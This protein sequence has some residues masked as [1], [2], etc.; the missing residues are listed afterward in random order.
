MPYTQKL[1]VISP[2]NKVKG[3]TTIT[4]MAVEQY[5]NDH[6]K[7]PHVSDGTDAISREIIKVLTAYDPAK[8]P[9]NTVYMELNQAE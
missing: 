9:K 6:G 8:N 1:I 3:E 4:A 5:Y 2:R 7:L